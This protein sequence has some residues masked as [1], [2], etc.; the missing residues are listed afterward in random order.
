M[1]APSPR[2]T[3]LWFQQDLRLRDNPAL[4]H[5]AERGEVIPVY[6]W[7]NAPG[8]HNL[9]G[10][11]KFWLHHSLRALHAALEAHGVRLLLLRGDP[12]AV[13]PELLGQTGADAV[14]WNRCYEPHAIEKAKSLKALLAVRAISAKSFKAGLLFEP[15]E[16][17]NQQGGF[18]KVFTPFWKRCLA[19]S[20][21]IGAP[22]GL[23]P[24]LPSTHC[25][26]SEDLHTWGL[27]PTRPDWSGGLAATWQPGE[28]SAQ[29]RLD[30]FL[31][32]RLGTYAANRDIPAIGTTSCLSPHLHWGEIS[33]RQIWHAARQTEARVGPHGVADK[34][35]S[36]LGWREFS[37]HL[38]FHVP[39]LPS[40][41]I[42]PKFDAFPWAQ[43]RQVLRA[44]QRGKT[45]YPL[46]DAGM[47]ELWATGYMHNRVRM[48][49][50]SFLTK[51]L[52]I[53]W[54]DG[55]AW[56]W[57]TLVDADLANNSASWQW[58]AG[59][60]ADAAPYYRI[61][62]PILQGERFDPSGAYVRRWVGE[63]SRLP[64]ADIHRPWEADASILQKAG[65]ALGQDYPFPIIGH[66]EARAAAL[67]A[68]KSL[69]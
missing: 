66:A 27:L 50:A 1:V 44:W 5:A 19:Q 15:W 8:P 51:H 31:E 37:Y 33:P 49:V 23:P 47:R 9:G 22:L 18:F 67:T 17:A 21:D 24:L 26:P 40:R 60:G 16:I 64:D 29:Q 7:E 12:L 53:D 36:E 6:V 14:V 32:N 61:F 52:L 55:A 13:I 45:G 28:C 42:N 58:V 34:F 69:A 35:L 11:S 25:A 20:G 68:Y 57:D 2:K 62:N 4:C 10:A 48:I 46:V 38:L 54:R 65:V 30:A 56:F 43:N 3:I 39:S 59:C 41:P 63:L